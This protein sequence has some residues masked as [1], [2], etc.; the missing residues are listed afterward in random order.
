[1]PPYYSWR[2]FTPINVLIRDFAP[3]NV[4][5][6]DGWI[7]PLLDDFAP[8]EFIVSNASCMK[9]KNKPVLVK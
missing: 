5:I 1:L 6:R 7:Q 2:H 8:L 9:Y 3:I 4:L